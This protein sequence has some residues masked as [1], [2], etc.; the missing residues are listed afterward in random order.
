MHTHTSENTGHAGSGDRNCDGLALAARYAY[1]PNSLSLCGPDN[2][3]LAWYAR[4]QNPEPKAKEI[5]A[6]FATLYPYLRLIATYNGIDDPFDRRVVTAYWTGNHLLRRVP[7]RGYVETLQDTIGLKKKSAY[8]DNAVV[9]DKIADG[10]LPHHAFHVLNVYRRTGHMDILHTVQTMDAC[11]VNWG[12]VINKLSTK[13]LVRS[14]P[15]QNIDGMLQFGP[16]VTRTLHTL[17]PDDTVAASVQTGDWVSYHWGHICERLTRQKLAY[18]RH[19]TQ[20]ALSYANA[21]DSPDSVRLG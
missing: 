16:R 12:K 5:F 9:Y 10:A 20:Q 6:K 3:E 13:I 17:G 18:L 2:T 15:L 8:R 7:V 4:T 14:S 1:A 11:I 21:T 19:L